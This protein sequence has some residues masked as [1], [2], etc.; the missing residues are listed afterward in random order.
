MKKRFLYVL[1]AF[2]LLVQGVPSA[3]AR[4]AYMTNSVRVAIK[5]YKGTNYSGCLQDCQNIV[6]RD[7]SNALAYYYMAMAYTKAGKK[8]LAVK[9]YSKVISLRPNARMVEYAATGKRCLETPDACHPAAATVE[10]SEID[11]FISSPYSAPL[12]PNVKL[13]YDNMQLNSIKNQINEGKSIDSYSLRRLNYKA[14]EEKSEKV[15]KVANV[16]PKKPTND[17]IAAALKVLRDAGLNPYSTDQIQAKAMVSAATAAK[18]NTYEQA[19][20]TQNPELAQLN[21]LMGGSGQGQN[22]NAMMNMVPFMLAQNK[23][24]TTNYSPQV[25]QSMIMNSMMSSMNFDGDNKNKQY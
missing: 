20:V 23:N 21:M 11:K 6:K 18:T 17:E 12:S 25:V 15:E 8:D 1:L 19:D 9:A 14:P 5:K 22:E 2:V 4:D 16:I 24:G 7:P 10:Q 3:F 13:D